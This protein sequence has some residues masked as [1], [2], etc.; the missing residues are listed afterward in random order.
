V[1]GERAELLVDRVEAG[2][3]HLKLS[4]TGSSVQRLATGNYLYGG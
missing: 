1:D 4:L 2:R 3:R